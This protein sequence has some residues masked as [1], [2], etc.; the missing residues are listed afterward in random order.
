[1]FFLA[2]DKERIGEEIQY[3]TFEKEKWYF[4]GRSD[5]KQTRDTVC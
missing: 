4:A 5:T 2:R 1:M 3:S